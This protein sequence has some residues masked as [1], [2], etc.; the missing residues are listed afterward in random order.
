MERQVISL[1]E[2]GK[3]M[4]RRRNTSS[5]GGEEVKSFFV[6]YLPFS[7]FTYFKH[8]FLDHHKKEEITAIKEHDTGRTSKEV[9]DDER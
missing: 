5:L 1:S 9:G 8:F 2:V 4:E 7:V 3:R 6:L